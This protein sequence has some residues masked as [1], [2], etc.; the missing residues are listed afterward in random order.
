MFLVSIY[1]KTLC[2]TDELFEA[3]PTQQWLSLLEPTQIIFSAQ[4]EREQIR[5][6]TNL[7]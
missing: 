5:V 1:P 2:K 4:L 7:R 6:Q 3:A